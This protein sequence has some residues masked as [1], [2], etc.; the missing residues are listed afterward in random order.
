MNPSNDDRDRLIDRLVDGE[1][2][3]A[4]RRALLALLDA[5]P[6]RDGWRRVALAFLEAQCWREAV[7]P[8]PATVAAQPPVLSA[9][10]ARRW[11]R[12]AA[13][14]ALAAGL[15][16]AFALGWAARP[17][18]EPRPSPGGAESTIV[19]TRPEGSGPAE[20]FAR[21]TLETPPSAV[22]QPVADVTTDPSGIDLSEWERL[23]FQV[24][25]RPRVVSVN[26]EGGRRV[27]LP[28]NEFRLRYVGDRTY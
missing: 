10:G 18:V 6:D 27:S 24:E 3:G 21:P 20:R 13:P 22:V 4:E 16:A 2:P 12:L 7:A 9:R 14:L 25:R 11:P 8:A 5:E 15:L 17:E 28:A 23:G 26:L 19:D 1:L